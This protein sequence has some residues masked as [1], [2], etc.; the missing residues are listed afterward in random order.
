MWKIFSAAVVV[1][2]LGPTQTSSSV[3]VLPL[4]RINELN[5]NVLNGGSSV[6][7][8]LV[9]Y[10]SGRFHLERRVQ[11]IPEPPAELSVFEAQLSPEQTEAL[12]KI[13]SADAIRRLPAFTPPAFPLSILT[14]DSL[15]VTIRLNGRE[16]TIGYLDWPDKSRN[17]SPNNTL[18]QIQ[19]DWRLTKGNLEPLQ[20]WV[21][22]VE[23]GNLKPTQ[24]DPSLCISL[25]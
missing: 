3:D 10:E 14:F 20:T 13:L 23:S 16:Q 12:K 5:E 22:D 7:D 1:I 15:F 18:E 6:R 24:V 11:R 2:A 9:V 19:Q 4:L 25:S 21:S 17:G 8:C